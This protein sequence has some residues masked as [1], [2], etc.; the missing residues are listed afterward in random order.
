MGVQTCA[1][2][3]YQYVQGRSRYWGG[4]AQGSATLASFGDW[5]LSADALAD[6]VRATLSDV[7]PAP[8]IPPLRLLG[9]LALKQGDVWALR[10]EVEH[11]TR[12]D[13]VAANETPTAAYTLTNMAVQ[14]MPIGDRITLTV[15][16]NNLFDVAARR[17][18]SDRKST[19][20][21]SSH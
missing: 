13:R 14:G 17:H 12:Q 10:G 1:R 5:A 16:A 4:E 15:A 2:P 19:R 11:A 21:N 3:S 20:L 18:A 7:G 8:R 6:Y 9:G